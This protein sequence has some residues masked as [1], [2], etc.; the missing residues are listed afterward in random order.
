MYSM[1]YHTYWWYKLIIYMVSFL[2][3][4]RFV[5]LFIKTA[6]LRASCFHDNRPEQDEQYVML[7][8]DCKNESLKQGS[9]TQNVQIA[10]VQISFFFSFHTFL[11][12]L[13]GAI[14]EC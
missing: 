14:A 2:I 6:S 4:Y 10:L 1:C 5:F 12:E 13:Q 9:A 8:P 11:K 7:T 3:S